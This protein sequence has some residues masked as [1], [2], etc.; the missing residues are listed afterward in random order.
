MESNLGTVSALWVGLTPPTNLKLVW[1]DSTPSQLC[2]KVYDFNLLAWVQLK[3]D[4]I[5]V[6]TYSELVNIANTVGLTLC[7]FFKI[8]DK[9]N[10]IALS[11]TAH[12]V[13]YT[14][15]LGNIC[16]DDL[17]ENVQYHVTS[18]NLLIDD[19]QGVFDN[20]NKKLVFTFTPKT[21]TLAD[22][23]FF[24]KK[25]MGNSFVLA[26]FKIS[27]LLS[28]VNGN[29]I[30]W[31]GGFFFDFK[32]AL[33]NNMDIEG[34]A[35]SAEAFNQYASSN[36]EALNTL[37]ES[38][39]T[40]VQETAD[41]IASEVTK[42][43]IYAKPLPQSLSV[44]TAID[45]QVNDTLF[46]ILSKIQ[47]WI[48]KFKFASGI[49]LSENF[50][51]NET[52]SNINNNDTVESA[53]RKVQTFISFW[54]NIVTYNQVEDETTF[55]KDENST[56]TFVGK[57]KFP[58][59]LGKVL[60]TD[61]TT[62]D[63]LPDYT[64]PEGN[65]VVDDVE[66]GVVPTST[67]QA[68]KLIASQNDST[69][70]EELLDNLSRPNHIPHLNALKWIIRFANATKLR[71]KNTYNKTETDAA[72]TAA[73]SGIQMMACVFLAPDGTS[74]LYKGSALVKAVGVSYNGGD[75][76]YD[77]TFYKDFA[78]TQVLELS[79]T[80]DMAIVNLNDTNRGLA[81]P[82]ISTPA[83]NI[84][85]DISGGDSYAYLKFLRVI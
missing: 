73:S 3:Q 56:T 23:Y 27:D 84:H 49:K 31:N 29:S 25:K 79:K 45:V 13:Q 69:T 42:D 14:D 75:D 50:V 78:K 20:D 35:V 34:G 4:V 2:H 51:A 40:I 41:A 68:A 28:A 80:T 67:T 15:G 24:G 5:S 77:V 38:Y 8:T 37:S 22:D 60:I 19:V 62:G 21:I 6:L 1:Y 65:N 70:N 32:S 48:N 55:G 16:I 61:P 12:K 18:S 71:F 85:I 66:F 59:L 81:T 7:K 57:L 83:N 26:K 9:G 76:V 17:G 63:L 44:G 53:L 36:D 52:T 58:T 33:S 11:I 10:A 74:S 72:I 43:K 64:L 82:F 30:G 54:I 47:N 39:Q 46:V